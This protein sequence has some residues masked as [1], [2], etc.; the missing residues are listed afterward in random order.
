MNRRDA[1]R[2]A[3]AAA[4]AAVFPKPT[5]EI[6]NVF[7]VPAEMI[8]DVPILYR[9]VDYLHLYEG[10]FMRWQADIEQRFAVAMAEKIDR[11]WRP[12]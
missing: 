5:S 11:D 12:A 6:A 9:H 10:D 4:I 2:T 8:P 7:G 3:A 1:F